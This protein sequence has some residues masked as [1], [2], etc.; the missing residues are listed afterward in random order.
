MLKTNENFM[1]K[2]RKLIERFWRDHIREY[3]EPRYGQ[4]FSILAVGVHEPLTGPSLLG[5]YHL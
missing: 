1:Q 5:N 4:I 2:Y 3:H